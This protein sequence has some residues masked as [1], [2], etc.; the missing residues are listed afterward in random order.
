MTFN[1]KFHQIKPGHKVFGGCV[2][3]I[4]QYVERLGPNKG[5]FV[6]HIA[7]QNDSDIEMSSP[8]QHSRMSYFRNSGLV[9]I[10][11][12]LLIN[13]E[14]VAQFTVGNDRLRLILAG[15]EGQ[16]DITRG[17]TRSRSALGVYTVRDADFN[18]T[19][20]AVETMKG[21]EPANILNMQQTLEDMVETFAN[22]QGALDATNAGLNSGTLLVDR[23]EVG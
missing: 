13:P 21:D 20:Q 9:E 10:L 3:Y 5:E 12:D 19:R 22:I 11:P 17:K 1:S 2:S 23:I 15:G 16:I 6:F 8:N 7:L 4:E 14:A 18:T